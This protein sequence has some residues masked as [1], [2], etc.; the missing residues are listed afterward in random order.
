MDEFK[1]KHYAHNNG[2]RC[3]LGP[4]GKWRHWDHPYPEPGPREAVDYECRMDHYIAMTMEDSLKVG[5]KIERYN[6]VAAQIEA[7]QVAD[8]MPAKPES[9]GS[10]DYEW[11]D[12]GDFGMP[13][14][15]INTSEIMD[16]DNP[17]HPLRTGRGGVPRYLAGPGS[18][19]QMPQGDH[20]EPDRTIDR[21]G[22]HV[23]YGQQGYHVE[24][25]TEQAR[26]ILGRHLP[27]AM[28]HFLE[29]N[30]EYGEG[31]A[32]VLGI[33]GQYADINRK[34][35]KLKRYLWDDIPVEPEAEPIAMV[36]A[37]LI[38]HLLILIDELEPKDA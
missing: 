38:G 4:D 33:K 23:D 35:I 3:I 15:G 27:V 37:E 34:V 17:L 9:D 22:V 25:A 2:R 8:Q 13:G 28:E 26:R 20:A 24:T 32:H 30:K 31:S 10:A 19:F 7:E 11:S 14:L 29:R 21:R 16:I 12:R 5:R 6:E 18:I 36:A 1:V